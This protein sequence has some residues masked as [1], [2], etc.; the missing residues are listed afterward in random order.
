MWHWTKMGWE[1]NSFNPFQSSVVF[2]TETIHLI[3]LK[4]KWMVSI[5]NAKLGW[6]NWVKLLLSTRLVGFCH[7]CHSVNTTKICQHRHEICRSSHRRCSMKKGVLVNSAKFKGKH[8]VRVSFLI[9]LLRPAILLKKGLQHSHFPVNFAKNFKNT[10]FTGN[11]RW[12]L[13][14]TENCSA[15]QLT[16]FYMMANFAFN[17]LIVIACIL[18]KGKDSTWLL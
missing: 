11:L 6:M 2:H 13:L 10:F 16:S 4:I 8:L 17:G 9:K 3:A 15:N 1:H 5:W 14:N 7:Y 18:T 12:L